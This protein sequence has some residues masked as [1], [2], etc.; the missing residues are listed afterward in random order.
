MGE[1]L[2][3]VSRNALKWFLPLFPST[4]ILPICLR[5]IKK[6]KKKFGEGWLEGSQIRVVT[7]FLRVK[8]IGP[9]ASSLLGPNY[10]CR[11]GI[12]SLKDENLPKKWKFSGFIS[13]LLFV[14]L[15]YGFLLNPTNTPRKNSVIRTGT[16]REECEDVCVVTFY[17]LY[18]H[19]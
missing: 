7:S 5:C 18:H 3:E 12:V 11:L 19:L 13:F 9:I 15:V 10:W 1:N 16:C 4:S 14:K 6:K 2:F 8:V 17:A